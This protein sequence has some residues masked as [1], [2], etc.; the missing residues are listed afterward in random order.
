MQPVLQLL[1]VIVQA[2]ARVLGVK[3]YFAGVLKPFQALRKLESKFAI[4]MGFLNSCR[5][6]R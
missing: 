2:Y 6:V 1:A 5:L 3:R 4:V